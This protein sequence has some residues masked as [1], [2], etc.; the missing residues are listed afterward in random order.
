MMEGTVIPNRGMINV[1]KMNLKRP[2]NVSNNHMC[3]GS[4]VVRIHVACPSSARTM[5][6]AIKMPKLTDEI[7]S[8]ITFVMIILLYVRS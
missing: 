8:Q 5:A 2:P 7:L 3:P 6:I 1:Q 4:I